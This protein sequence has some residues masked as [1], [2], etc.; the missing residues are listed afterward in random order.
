[1][2][3]YGFH[4]VA[5]ITATFDNLVIFMRLTHDMLAH[6]F[7]IYYDA[8]LRHADLGAFMAREHSAAFT[9]QHDRFH[10]HIAAVLEA[11]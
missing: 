11:S 9:T 10:L 1:M 6:L 5:G 7:G 2:K 8:T 3:H 4:D